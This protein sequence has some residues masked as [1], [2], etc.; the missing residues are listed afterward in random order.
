MAITVAMGAR[1]QKLQMPVHLVAV[2]PVA[3]TDLATAS[4]Q[5]NENAKPLG[6]KGMEWFFEN[7]IARK[8]DL[9]DPRLNLVASAPLK[10][11]PQVTII[12]D[13]IDPL[14]SEGVM[15]AKKLQ[16]AGVKVKSKNYEGVTH[17][18]FGMAAVIKEADDAQ[19]FAVEELKRAFDGKAAQN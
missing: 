8:A 9:K 3:G 1:D 17:E 16:A 12:T 2:Y 13:D 11:L 18:F 14:M 7:E 10:G 4:Y 15:L 5:K 19:N 6:K